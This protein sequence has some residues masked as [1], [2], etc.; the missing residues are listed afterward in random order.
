M[1]ADDTQAI[2]GSVVRRGDAG[3][4]RTRRA[5]LWNAWK[6]ER[7]PELIVSATSRDDVCAA[8]RLARARRLR[9][10]VRGG[11]HSWWGAPVR[12]GGMLI[13][14][15]LLRDVDIDQESRSAWLGPV[16]SNRALAATL[17]EHGLAF[18]IGHCGEVVA[19]G[20]LLAGGF[21]WNTRAWGPACMSVREIEVVDAN[22]DVVRASEQENADLFWAARGAGAGFF[23]VA[24]RFRVQLYPLPRAMAT[25]SAVFAPA[26]W[27]E[28]AEW[29]SGLVETLD[30]IAEPSLL[31]APAPPQVTSSTDKVAIL[32]VTAFADTGEQAAATL[33]PVQACPVIDRAL[34]WDVA[35]PATFGTLFDVAALSW[36]EGRRYAGDT[37]WTNADLTDVVAR[38]RD[39]VLAAPSRESLI[40]TTLSPNP[41]GTDWTPHAAFTMPGRILLDCY[42]IWQQ[43]ADDA[44]NEAWLR[45]VM[46]ALEPI[47]VGHYMGEADLTAAP[48]RAARCYPEPTWRRL[49]KLRTRFD[50]DGV[51]HTYPHAE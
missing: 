44:A 32:S 34:A 27:L 22:G 37:A 39:V 16:V 31:L 28:V 35:K 12:D 20:Y 33:A 15:S 14:L 26:D 24:T 5:M 42:A 19:S 29:A 8:V 11:G 46:A 9:V 51:F 36:P 7:Y 10:A 21:G 13:D 4:E 43:P 45:A 30:P 23:G 17:A 49:Q 1:G 2:R 6:P 48:T 25:S 3:Y 50:P 38:L 47:T 41:A 40:L 18:P